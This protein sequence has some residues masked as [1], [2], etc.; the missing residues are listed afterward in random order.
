MKYVKRITV[1]F[2][3]VIVA[4]G[5]S[6][7]RPKKI[8]AN[9]LV[10]AGEAL[11]VLFG[12]LGATGVVVGF[13][14][15]FEKRQEDTL[16]F[17]EDL[18]QTTQ[19]AYWDWYNAGQL[20]TSDTGH[21][22]FYP[23]MEVDTSWYS[24]LWQ[25][26]TD[27]VNSTE[28]VSFPVAS[29]VNISYP[30][31]GAVE[32]T[33]VSGLVADSSYFV[34]DRGP[35]YDVV[36]S[37]ASDSSAVRCSL[38]KSTG[39]IYNYEVFTNVYALHLDAKGSANSSYPDKI[40]GWINFVRSVDGS[41]V[42][43][44]L[45][46]FVVTPTNETSCGLR[47]YD[48]SDVWGRG[49]C[50]GVGDVLT[51]CYGVYVDVDE[52]IPCD[53]WVGKWDDAVTA[54]R[55]VGFVTGQDLSGYNNLNDFYDV[56]TGLVTGLNV[57]DVPVV[58]DPVVP[59]TGDLTGIAGGLQ[60]IL[61]WLK[62]L[63][64][65]LIKAL[66]DLLTA[67][68]VP[69]GAA[70]NDFFDPIMVGLKDKMDLDTFENFKNRMQSLSSPPA[71]NVTMDRDGVTYTVIDFSSFNDVRDKLW[72]W[73]RG[74]LFVFILLYNMNFVYKLIRGQSMFDGM[75]TMLLFGWSDPGARGS[76]GSGGRDRG[77]KGH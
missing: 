60:S 29:S 21:T 73:L 32:T 58:D 76:S 43:F 52:L 1:F 64:D 69:S 3:A 71:P 49:V 70:F 41:A 28:I 13:E 50:A 61:D 18:P 53:S 75:G 44:G 33:L 10:L 72:D 16:Q 67:L 57:S 40:E 6:L 46:G 8:Y 45:G 38:D 27:I 63:I 39:G 9:E 4:F 2:L 59:I 36:Y 24:D 56:E 17:F 66:G 47:F 14:E 68:F 26:V 23:N 42:S 77:G 51:L 22:V 62:G 7:Y 35:Y 34:F 25:S 74:Y 12:L 15:T 19:D 31:F 11:D 37:V 65:K 30:A 48:G 5:C 20:V 55:Q 54:D